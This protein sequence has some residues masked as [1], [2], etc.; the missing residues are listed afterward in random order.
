M[1]GLSKQCFSFFLLCKL[2]ADDEHEV[3]NTKLRISLEIIGKSN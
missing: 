3:Q 1:K 2:G